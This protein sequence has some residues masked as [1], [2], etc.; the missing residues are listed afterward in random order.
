MILLEPITSQDCEIAGRRR[1]WYRND[2]TA[3]DF[4]ASKASCSLVHAK[5]R[6]IKVATNLVLHLEHISEVLPR[7][8]G[9]VCTI[10]SILP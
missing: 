4:E 9:A 10:D 5:G 7:W 3:C 2:R 1:E 6:E 8:D